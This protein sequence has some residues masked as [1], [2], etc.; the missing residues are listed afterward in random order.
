MGCTEEGGISKN[1]RLELLP[2][3]KVPYGFL[4]GAL[5]L[6]TL[7][8]GIKREGKGLTGPSFALGRLT[9]VL[10]KG[11]QLRAST[12]SSLSPLSLLG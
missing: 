2:I 6:F 10:D 1:S 7:A 4:G 9:P 5:A 8:G 12:F 3:Q 11:V